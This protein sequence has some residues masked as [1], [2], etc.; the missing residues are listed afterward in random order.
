MATTRRFKFDKA[1]GISVSTG[2]THSFSRGVATVNPKSEAVAA[3][4]PRWDGPL[5]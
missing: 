2:L 1:T 3:N 4:N 5:L